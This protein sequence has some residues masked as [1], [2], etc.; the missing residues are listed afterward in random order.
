MRLRAAHITSHNRVV[1]IAKETDSPGERPTVIRPNWP[2]HE[3]VEGALGQITRLPRTYSPLPLADFKSP[4][5]HACRIDH[6][7]YLSTHIDLDLTFRGEAAGIN[8]MF[9]LWIFSTAK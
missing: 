1:L 7:Y 6:R 5:Q 9:F 2:S 3:V 4:I 8:S